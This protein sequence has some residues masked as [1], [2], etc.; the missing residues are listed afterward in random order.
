[1]KRAFMLASFAGGI[2]V[3]TALQSSS[4]LGVIAVILSVL[5]GYALAAYAV[6]RVA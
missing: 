4:S 5:I 6:G 1:M 2:A 3:S